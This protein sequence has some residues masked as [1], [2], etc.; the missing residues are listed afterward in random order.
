[1]I[2]VYERACREDAERG[3]IRPEQ[4]LDCVDLP[5]G[6]RDADVLDGVHELNGNSIEQGKVGTL[7]GRRQLFP[8]TRGGAIL[9]A[10]VASATQE[11]TVEVRE[12]APPFQR[13]EGGV[14]QAVDD[15]RTGPAAVLGGVGGGRHSFLRILFVREPISAVGLGARLARPGQR[16]RSSDQEARRKVHRIR[17]PPRG[18]M[19]TSRTESSGIQTGT[20]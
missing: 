10:R 4:S 5:L 11:R 8:G 15:L 6:L 20:T 13:L 7:R 18:P 12:P 1:L 14:A 17:W 19:R 2:S 3:M 9:L 16:V